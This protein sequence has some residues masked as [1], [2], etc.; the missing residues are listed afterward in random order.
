VKA[1]WAYK[2][3]LPIHNRMKEVV[4]LT[5]KAAQAELE[6]ARRKLRKLHYGS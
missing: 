3:R 2:E 4:G 5:I 1:Q 6:A